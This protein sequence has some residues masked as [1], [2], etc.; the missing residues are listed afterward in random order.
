[1]TIPEDIQSKIEAQAII[2][3]DGSCKE[4]DHTHDCCCSAFEEGAEFG[5]SLAFEEI[6]YLEGKKQT[7]A[8]LFKAYAR[9]SREKKQKLLEEIQRLNQSNSD[10]TQQAKDLSHM[11]IEIM[12]ENERL[13]EENEKLKAFV[14]KVASFHPDGNP[15]MPIKEANETH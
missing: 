3:T 9:S 5:Y 14:A 7:I 11:S 4:N 2:N 12:A 13:K 15:V 8:D 1:M 10:F 6:E